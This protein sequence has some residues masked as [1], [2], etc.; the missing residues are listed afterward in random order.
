MYFLL[1]NICEFDW[2]LVGRQNV[3]KSAIKTTGKTFISVRNQVLFPF[4]RDD[5][6][7]GFSWP[8]IDLRFAN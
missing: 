5:N 3:E 2:D 1:S 6:F 8:A 4:V 7:R